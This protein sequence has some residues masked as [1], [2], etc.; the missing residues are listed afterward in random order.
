[1]P[2]RPVQIDEVDYIAFSDAIDQVSGSSAQNQRE[3]NPRQPLVG[4]QCS[5][6]HRQRRQSANGHAREDD[7]LER[8][9]RRV[10]ESERGASVMDARQVEEAGNHRDAFVERDLAPDYRL[11][12]LIQHDDGQS[13]PEIGLPGVSRH[14]SGIHWLGERFDAAV[15]DA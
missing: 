9:I 4:R 11:D 8:K 6:V 13:D 12:D 3:P 5:R 1:V 7:G 2:A 10:H 15:A 14:A